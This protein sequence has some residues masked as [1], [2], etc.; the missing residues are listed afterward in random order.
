VAKPVLG[1]E[2]FLAKQHRNRRAQ[3]DSERGEKA[4]QGRR[5]YDVAQKAEATGAHRADDVEVFGGNLPNGVPN[6][7]EH[8]AEDDKRHEKDFCGFADA[9]K[10]HYYREKRRFG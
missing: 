1:N 4:G 6:G 8:L 3:A 7:D 5:N 9:E 10:K 2:G